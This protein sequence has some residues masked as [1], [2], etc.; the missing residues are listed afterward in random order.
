M[1][2][3]TRIGWCTVISLAALIL[4]AC[5]K[6]SP[7]GPQTPARVMVSS[8]S[9][10]L[11]SLGSTYQLT[12]TV[13]DRYS[14]PI[15]D[16]SVT[17][18]SSEGSVATVNAAGLITAV[19]NGSAQITATAG[20]ASATAAVTVS[21]TAFR[22]TITPTSGLLTEPG[23]IL[24]LSATVLDENGRPVDGAPV[25]W[26]SS[27]GSVAGVD[28][29]GV[30]TAHSDGIVQITASTG[31]LADFVEIRV[32]FADPDHAAL[33]VLYHEMG[34]P[35]WTNQTNWM[36]GAPLGEWHGVT[37][38]EM[39]RVA[40]LNLAGNGLSGFLPP[41]IG[42]L[43]RVNNL[44]LSNNSLSGTIP[45]EIGQLTVLFSLNLAG[46]QLSGPLLPEIGKLTS[47][48]SLELSGNQLSGS[49]PSELGRLTGLAFLF[50]PGN[51]FTG[52]IPSEI[53]QLT[54]LLFLD[55]S[56]NQLTGPLPPELGQLTSLGFLDILY[57]Q[58]TGPL[59]PELGQLKALNS[60]D[61]SFN[62]ITGSLPPEWSG[63]TALQSMTL[64]VNQMTGSLP[65]ELGMMSNLESLSISNNNLSGALPTE[66]G[67]LA[68]LR[69]LSLSGNTGLS[70]P[71][72]G[73][74]L[75]LGLEVLSLGGTGLC[76]PR[77]TEFEV[78]LLGIQIKRVPLCGEV[79][80]AR[81]Y[82]TQA[83][84]SL[85]FPVPLVAGEQALLRVFVT[86]EQ[87]VNATLPP[88]RATFYLDG[89]PSD[90]IEIPG[91]GAPIPAGI[92]LEI[93][94]SDLS[95]TS[96]LVVP[97]E[98]VTPG[99]EMVIEIDPD[100]TL[101]PALGI[102]S[103]IPAVGRMPVEVMT[104]PALDL[105]LI[106]FLWTEDPDGTVVPDPGVS[107]DDDIFWQSRDLLPVLDRE[108]SVTL[109]EPVWTSVDPANRN[110]DLVINDVLMIQI[111]DG[112]TGHYMGIVREGG[113]ALLPGKTSVAPF[114]V[115]IMAHELGHNMGLLHAPCDVFDPDPDYPYA[116]GTIGSW[117][118]DFRDGTLVSPDTFDLMSYC[119][120]GWVSDYN[121]S[122]A[123]AVRQLEDF[124]T[125]IGPPSLSGLL[126]RGGV[127]D[128]GVLYLEPSFVVD[129]PTSLPRSD[130]PY[131]LSGEDQDGNS[132]FSLSFSMARIADGEGGIFA[133]VLPAQSAWRFDLERITLSGPEGVA[134]LSADDET[135][136]T[137][138][139]LMDQATGRVRGILRDYPGPVGGTQAARRT[140]PEPGLDIVISSGIPDPESW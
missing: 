43:N 77:E 59:P 93:V 47:L 3:M 28:S 71:I 19:E 117:G 12:A 122:R 40:E 132:L 92:P 116:N 124:F 118:Y 70:G 119:K 133:F 46:N 13:F 89:S 107:P 75:G 125:F 53:G 22:I 31:G 140:V 97:G 101:D 25:Q 86:A 14:K 48:S 99:L 81:A 84:Q 36:T 79:I 63:M 135:S 54:R 24:Q 35:N 10:S 50:L 139:L 103:R 41:A 58:L 128:E 32:M 78:W 61:L 7:T 95:S 11:S 60:L 121:F 30:V 123:I 20:G 76:V 9:V 45:T 55:L 109:R 64:S 136:S 56:G 34:G 88:M 111:M 65:S 74:F 8:M 112:A 5:G 4:G 21:Q 87:G 39:G 90:P 131:R 100:G 105:T 29:G 37:T 16:A 66:L 98:F 2:S 120:P 33:V 137:T 42:M 82:L 15:S 130:G 83:T 27:D 102:V 110:L 115:R 62:E 49:L 106:P 18:T 129:A 69:S 96:N 1:S 134:E 72:P 23:E 26:S 114:D 6:D 38:D 51:Q 52:S 67:Q 113:L 68:K 85:L 108:F 94:E 91:S 127:D 17:W 126:I 57:N 44:D 104:V 138:A 73:S 80:G